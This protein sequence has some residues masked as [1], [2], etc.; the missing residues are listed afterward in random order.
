MFYD[1]SYKYGIFLNTPM[2]GLFKQIILGYFDCSDQPHKISG[3]SNT[4]QETASHVRTNLKCRV[5][6]YSEKSN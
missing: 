1:V 5:C 3:S 2:W 4:V 6:L